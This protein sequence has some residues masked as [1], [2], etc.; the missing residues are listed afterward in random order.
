MARA[1]AACRRSV[2]WR[3][4]GWPVSTPASP[5][6]PARGPRGLADPRSYN[7]R[8]SSS[9]Q[10]AIKTRVDGKQQEANVYNGGAGAKST[11]TQAWRHAA[12]SQL[13]PLSGVGEA[14]SE[15]GELGAGEAQVVHRHA[16]RAGVAA[17]ARYVAAPRAT[18][19]R[20]NSVH[21]L[22]RAC[23][24]FL[25]LIRSTGAAHRGEGLLVALDGQHKREYAVS[26]EKL[27]LRLMQ[28]AGQ[29]HCLPATRTARSPS[30]P[31]Y[32]ITINCGACMCGG[33][34]CWHRTGWSSAR[35]GCPTYRGET[36]GR[37]C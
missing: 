10:T 2:G 36:A 8:R 24:G 30:Q 33:W 31:T 12:L 1:R 18:L 34:Q 37:G 6:C 4:L 22:Q 25:S 29:V 9:K 15:H 13:Q 17:Q 26:L 32:S 7:P 21:Q 5:A 20:A 3:R 27:Q 19:L 23:L 16:R 35:L 14:T 11:P 28:R